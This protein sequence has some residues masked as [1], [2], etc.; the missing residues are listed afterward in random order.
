MAKRI[1]I[2]HENRMHLASLEAEVGL[3]LAAVP[4]QVAEKTAEIVRGIRNGTPYMQY[5]G[6]R[7]SY[8]D[9]HVVSV[10]VGW[11]YRLILKEATTLEPVKIVSHEDYINEF[12]NY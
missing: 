10:P 12:R 9:R 1:A 4:P 8:N 7:L 6:K 3:G 2:R 5:H 11:S